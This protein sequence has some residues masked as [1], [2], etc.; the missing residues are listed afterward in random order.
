MRNHPMFT[1]RFEIDDEC[2]IVIVSLTGD[3]DPTAVEDLHPQIQELVRAGYRRFVFDL[4]DLDH[5]GSIALRLFIAL[6]RQVKGEGGVVFCG[7]SERIATLIE[8]TN[9]DRILRA[10]PTCDLAMAALESPDFR[11]PPDGPANA[12]P[13]TPRF[14][15]ARRRRPRR[16]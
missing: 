6:A 11:G 8:L 14:A 16:S 1:S 4:Y 7:I 12:W 9:V 5:L 10:F 13:L 3:L 2:R 15:F